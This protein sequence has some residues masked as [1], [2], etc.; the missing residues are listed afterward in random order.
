ACHLL[1]LLRDN[2][3]G[4]VAVDRKRLI[5]I[6]ALVG[7]MFVVFTTLR[8]MNSSEPVQA[9]VQTIVEEVDY[10]QVLAVAEPMRMGQRISEGDLAWIDWPTEAVTAA[11]IVDD[12]EAEVSVMDSLIGAVVREPLTPG[13]PL[14]M[15]RFIQAGDAGVMAALLSPGMRA[16]T[17]RISVDTAAGGFIQPGDK[18]DIILQENIQPDFNAG[19]SGEVQQVANTIFENVTVLAI[20]QSFS[21]G[22]TGGAALPGSTATLEL[23]P[24]D[25]ER[26]TV[27]QVRGDLSLVLRGFSGSSARAQSRANTQFE[28]EGSIPPLTIYRSGQPTNV[29]VRGG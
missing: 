10:T 16:V 24:Q 15:S 13:D 27:A 26:I 7:L 1:R 12:P 8:G 23:S 3:F 17:V 4:A 25:A 5:L 21:S 20:D 29:A 2:P 6:I 19:G 18:V 9:E 22:E 11:L 14:V 28:E